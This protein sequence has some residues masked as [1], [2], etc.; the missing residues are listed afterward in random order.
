MRKNYYNFI[1]LFSEICIFSYQHT[2]FIFVCV[3]R[4][5]ENGHNVTVFLTTDSDDKMV[6]NSN[7]FGDG[8]TATILS[9]M[10]WNDDEWHEKQRHWPI[11]V[12]VLFEN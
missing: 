2:S 1:S 8:I 6:N 4:L 10:R 3:Y 5:R 11:K 7:A 9:F 12:F